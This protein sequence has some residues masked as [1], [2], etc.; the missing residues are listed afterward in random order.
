MADAGT[1]SPTLD[2]APVVRALRRLEGRATVADISAAT[3][4]ERAESEAV[5][6]NLLEH[7]R[8]HLEVGERGDLVY[9]F[10]KGL[11]TRDAESLWT[12]IKRGTLLVFAFVFGPDE[13]V[14]TQHDKDREMLR[15]VRARRGVV[16]ATDLVQMTG[17]ELA[18]AEGELGRLMAAHDG[19]VEVTDRGTLLYTFPDLM[20]SAQGTVR[21]REPAP[22]WRRRY[23]TATTRTNYGTH[24]LA[25]RPWSPSTIRPQPS[26]MESPTGWPSCDDR[27]R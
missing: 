16:S 7:R 22:A 10:D 2:P 23:W 18:E 12:R 6:R 27:A 1:L 14:R 25:S 17:M 9:R 4:L 5:L 24:F 13:P 19:E 11:L 15:F 21:E 8:G 20:V 3:G 26:L